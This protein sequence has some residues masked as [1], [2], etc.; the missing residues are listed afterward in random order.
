MPWTG[1]QGRSACY[2]CL[3]T[4][5]WDNFFFEAHLPGLAYK[6]KGCLCFLRSL[7]C[8]VSKDVIKNYQRQTFG[9]LYDYLCNY[10]TTSTGKPLAFCLT[11]GASCDL[12]TSWC[13]GRVCACLSPKIHIYTYTHTCARYWCTGRVCAC[14]SPKHT[15]THTHLLI[16][17]GGKI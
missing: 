16:C 4:F 10:Q 6:A 5:Y 14:L 7:W 3:S 12:I 13:T 11:I 1:Q 2:S 15:H 17:V 9:Y 8:W